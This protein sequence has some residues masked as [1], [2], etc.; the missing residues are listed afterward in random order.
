MRKLLVYTILF[1]CSLNAAGQDPVFSQIQFGLTYLNPAYAGYSG[2]LTLNT[3]S[4]IQ[5]NPAP[6]IFNFNSFSANIGCTESGLGFGLHAFNSSQG[7]GF[8]QT[9]NLAGLVSATRRIGRM[10]NL[11]A[12]IQIGAGQHSIDW[13]KFTFTSQ[14]DPY[15]GKYTNVSNVFQQRPNSNAFVDVSAGVRFRSLLGQRKKIGNTN[16]YLSGG[17]AMFHINQPEESFFGE[18]SRREI[19]YN[20]H[21]YY[22]MRP[23]L[24]MKY[25]TASD[26]TDAFAVGYV[27]HRQ[28]PLQTNTISLHYYTHYQLSISLGVR[29]M[30]VFGVNENWDSMIPNVTYTTNFNG[31]GVIL[32]FG[33]SIDLPIFELGRG[34]RLLTHEIGVTLRFRNRQMCFGIGGKSG[35]FQRVSK[36]RADGCFNGYPDL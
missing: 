24:K 15:V 14:L 31:K 8:L 3:Q 11:T 28:N 33:Y 20:A 19:R 34:N 13:D 1:L 30:Q 5:W 21:L 10:T 32:D 2:D 7:E 6:G 26:E 17:F 36:K 16:S 4:R 23:K 9:N 18:P 29:R 12:G 25:R 22:Y 27:Y 35:K